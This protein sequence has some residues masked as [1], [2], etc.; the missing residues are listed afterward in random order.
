MHRLSSHKIVRRFKI[1]SFLLLLMYP[2][3]PVSIIILFYGVISRGFD[4][5]YLVAIFFA[6]WIFL[7]ILIY[8]KSKR[9]ICPLCLGNQ[10]REF[11]CIKHKKAEKLLGSYR[12]KVAVSILSKNMFRCSY[13][14][15]NTVMQVRM[16][17][18]RS[19]GVKSP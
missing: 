12:A 16:R 7:K 8:I 2:L 14:G 17:C 6:F 10:Y 1:V 18:S 5:L 4:L 19:I 15:E 3:L 9:L 11:G 13:C